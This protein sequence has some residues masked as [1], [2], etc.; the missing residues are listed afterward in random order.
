MA[1]DLR[2]PPLIVMP[3]RGPSD[4]YAAK[5][6]LARAAREVAVEA[7]VY[8]SVGSG[9][10]LCVAWVRVFVAARM[11]YADVVDERCSRRGVWVR[12]ARGCSSK[13]GVRPPSKSRGQAA[14]QKPSPLIRRIASAATKA[15]SAARSAR[16]TGS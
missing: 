11:R 9:G 8:A 3:R 12:D 5:Q 6:A 4:S 7:I 14:P 13:C 1:L 10:G 2:V 15:R 16:S